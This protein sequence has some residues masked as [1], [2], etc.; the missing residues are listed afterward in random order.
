MFFM[1]AVVYQL[2][3]YQS[4]KDLERLYAELKPY[5]ETEA[6]TDTAPCEMNPGY[7]APEQDPA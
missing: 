5:T 4:K 6:F 1:T 3:D 7:V 2:R